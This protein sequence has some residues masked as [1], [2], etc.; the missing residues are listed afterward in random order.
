M[1][2]YK[3]VAASLAPYATSALPID[4]S[5]LAAWSFGLALS[6][7]SLLGTTALHAGTCVE[8]VAGV[9]ICSGPAAG[10]DT[11]E[12]LTSGDPTG[13]DVS[14]Q[15][16]FGISTTADGAF[17]LGA[18]PGSGGLTFSD[19]NT[20]TISGSSYGIDA[21]NLGTGNLSITSTGTVIGAGSFGV[22]AYNLGGSLTLNFA[23]VQAD[24]TAIIAEQYGSGAL[25]ITASGAVTSTYGA[26]ILAYNGG[27]SSTLVETTGSVS[28]DTVGIFAVGSGTSTDLT[29]KTA[30]VAGGVIGID[31]IHDGTGDLMIT[32]TGTVTGNAG[33]AA[34]I[35]FGVTALSCNCSS[36][37]TILTENVTSQQ[38][39]LA[40]HY[41]S[42]ALSITSTGT[43]TTNRSGA[44][45]AVERSNYEANFGGYGAGIEAFSY[46]S[47][48]TINAN[49]IQSFGDGIYGYN[50]YG[51]MSVTTTGMVVAGNSAVTGSYDRD[52]IELQNRGTSLTVS[53]NI[54]TGT[55]DGI[56]AN[57]YGTGELRITTTGLI[58][59]GAN[60]GSAF[61]AS[62]NG[63]EAY[64][65]TAGTDVIIG[66]TSVTGNDEGIDVANLGSG[67]LSITATGTVQGG[68]VSAS[69]SASFLIGTRNL[70]EGIQAYN[71]VTGGNV[72]INVADVSGYSH[73]INVGNFGTG[74]TGITSTG[75]VIGGKSHYPNALPKAG[76]SVTDLS[77]YY[78]ANSADGITAT[79]AVNTTSMTIMA[80]NV[81][82]GFDGIYADH[83]GSGALMITATGTVSGGPGNYVSTGVVT[84]A[85]A[86]VAPTVGFV[87]GVGINASNAAS[88]TDLTINANSVSGYGDAIFAENNGTGILSITTTGTVT[89]GKRATATG[90]LPGGI[91]Y[92][93]NN[94]VGN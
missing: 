19:L 15:P 78:G 12:V 10:G 50:A 56:E 84:T 58:T 46:G 62:G 82:G 47:G 31:A 54:V 71:G 85:P 22:Q 3:G 5:R 41:G 28:G 20:S 49:N 53:A 86:L 83:N 80:N 93:A 4:G 34:S 16:G 64:N 77:N 7:A 90:V 52:G 59:G 81:Y 66:V 18:F 32:T 92:S 48:L 2:K 60:E 8:G 57:N 1:T 13:L 75:T 17:L 25:S 72:T 79:G 70:G 44:N 89:G 74:A 68:V 67:N 6:A 38:G 76:V 45:S 37:M 11:T 63:I 24:A 27:T 87:S 42:G 73:G 21:Y 35:G 14:T 33:D 88:G 30:D 61:L 91:T 23:T 39:I 94:T 9:W 26:G 29:V 43:I 40:Y 36:N 69:P 51:A 55:D 65:S